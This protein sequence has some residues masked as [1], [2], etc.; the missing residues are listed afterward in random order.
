LQVLQVLDPNAGLSYELLAITTAIWGGTPL[1]GGKGSV[2]G[3]VLGAIF[4]GITQNALNL[5]NVPTYYQQIMIGVVLLLLV[6]FL[7]KK[8]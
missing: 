3:C 1:S 2:I 7:K 4:M 6:L 5:L 8:A